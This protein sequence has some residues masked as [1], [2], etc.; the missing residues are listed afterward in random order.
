MNRLDEQERAAQLQRDADR[1]AAT[2]W[3]RN[4]AWGAAYTAVGLFSLAVAGLFA[5]KAVLAFRN[6]RDLVT[7][8]GVSVGRQW[9]IE[10]ATL[11][12]YMQA[13]LLHGQAD[14]ERAKQAPPVLPG[15]KFTDAR[16][17]VY[18]GRTVSP[19]LPPL[20][21]ELLPPPAPSLPIP[22]LAEVMNLRPKDGVIVGY[23]RERTPL[24]LSLDAIGACLVIGEGRTGKSST[25]AAITTQLAAMGSTLFLI[26]PHAQLRDSLA[27][28]L[29]PLGDRLAMVVSTPEQAEGV[30]HAVTREFQDRLNGDTGNPVF[31]LV[32]ELNSMTSGLWDGVG[33]AVSDL[34]K[35]LAFQGGKMQMGIIAIAHLATVQGMGSHLAYGARTVLAHRTLTNNISKWVPSH[36]ARQVRDLGR[37]ELLAVHEGGNA[38]LRVPR[39]EPE[40]VQA[41]VATFSPTVVVPFQELRSAPSLSTPTPSLLTETEVFLLRLARDRFDG[42]FPINRMFQTLRES[43]Q[44]LP[45]GEI[46]RAGTKLEA[47]G[48]LAPPSTGPRG[49]VPRRLTEKALGVI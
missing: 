10:G 32:D 48:Y 41:A 43:D 45:Q 23:D 37:G 9:A 26:D 35:Q 27:M 1:E 2:A 42:L 24:T 22:S 14:V 21:P 18:G 31:L 20:T 12:A 16:K 38:L 44:A 28:R 17:V 15:A 39:S 49:P 19:A 13:V 30:L 25:V 7:Y 46:E 47:W 8:R 40:D 36:L 5:G 29:A 11:P 34:A 33:E 4:L 6:G 3:A